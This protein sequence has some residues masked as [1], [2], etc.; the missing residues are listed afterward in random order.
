MTR[1]NRCAR[2]LGALLLALPLAVLPSCASV[3]FERNTET[4]GTFVSTGWAF[5]IFS[6]DL[7]KSAMNIARENASDAK[8]ANMV[9]ETASISPYFG[10]FDWVLDIVGLRRA[11][12][13]GTWGFAGD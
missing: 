13:K 1:R 10:W 4:S 7:P 5:T 6:I 2:V 3:S 9:V 11:R 8:R 12:I